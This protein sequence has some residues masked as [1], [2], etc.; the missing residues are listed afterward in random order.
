MKHTA[1]VLG[2][3]SELNTGLA[4]RISELEQQ[5]GSLRAA[6]KVLGC[7]AGYLSRLRSGEKENPSAI[8]LKRIGLRRV[9][10]YERIK[11]RNWKR[12]KAE[13]TNVEAGGTMLVGKYKIEKAEDGSY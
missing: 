7:D 9:I 10:S 5:H 11:P 2:G 4:V 6:A 1:I 3:E 12:A 8:L 13:G